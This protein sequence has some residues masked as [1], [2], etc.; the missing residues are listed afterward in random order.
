MHHTDNRKYGQHYHA[1]YFAACLWNKEVSNFPSNTNRTSKLAFLL[2]FSDLTNATV[3]YTFAN[4]I[5]GTCRL[6]CHSLLYMTDKSFSNLQR[7]LL[8]FQIIKDTAALWDLI[9]SKWNNYF[10]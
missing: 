4:V 7:Q 3:N 1:T 8:E 5:L 10:C 2:A 6:I 9:K